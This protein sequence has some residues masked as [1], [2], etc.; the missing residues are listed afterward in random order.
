MR[1]STLRSAPRRSTRSCAS[2]KVQGAG[3]LVETRAR[4]LLEAFLR[5][6]A[7]RGITPEAYFQVT[8]Q[9]PE[10]LSA[11]IRTEAAQSVARELALEAVAEKAGISVTDDESGR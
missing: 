5:S 11:Q 1:R 4:E 10:L 3:P 7:S 2:R 9:T 6:L 8:G